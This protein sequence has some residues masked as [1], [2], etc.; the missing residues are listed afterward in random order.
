MNNKINN[1]LLKQIISEIANKSKSGRINDLSWEA[2]Y[3]AKKKRIKEADEK[4]PAAPKDN[5]VGDD[6]EKGLPPLKGQDAPQGADSAE[7]GSGNLPPLDKSQEKG[8]DKAATPA[9]KPN[10]KTGASADKTPAM[11]AGEESGGDEEAEKAKEDAVKAKA[12]LEKAKA[13]KDQAE[14]ELK[15]QSYVK[16]KSSGGTQFMLTK[17]LGQAFKTNT[18]DALATEMA[19][20]LKISTQEDAAAFEEDMA[21]YKNILGM[22]NL[23][24][25]IKAIAVKPTETPEEPTD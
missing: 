9:P 2:I 24:S 6:S 14:K 20:K 11:P 15:Q 1:P 21:L 3:E 22:T 13:E 18:I 17:I 23:I 12:E 4:S 10:E 8:Q 5:A 16:L 25:S 7:K 19:Q